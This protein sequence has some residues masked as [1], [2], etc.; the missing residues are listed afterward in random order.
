MDGAVSV[1]NLKGIGKIIAQII[2]PFVALGV[3]LYVNNLNGSDVGD[4]YAY[5]G[6]VAIAVVAFFFGQEKPVKTLVTV[7]VLAAAAMTIG[8]LTSGIVSVYAFMAGGLF[9]SVMWPCIFALGIGGLGNIR[10]K[11]LRSLL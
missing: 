10:V 6:C 5:A 4:L 1:F 7:S 11:G 9:C 3:V 2:I 8:V